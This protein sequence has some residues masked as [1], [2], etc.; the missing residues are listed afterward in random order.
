L[1]DASIKPRRRVV[2]V[3]R[4]QVKAAQLRV[5]LDKRLG[6]PTPAIIMEIANAKQRARG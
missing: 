3:S 6:E 1:T 5:D 2:N 4:T